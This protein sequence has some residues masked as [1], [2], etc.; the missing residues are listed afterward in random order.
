[1]ASYEVEAKFFVA[2]LAQLRETLLTLGAEQKKERVFEKNIRFETKGNGL[3]ANRQLLRLRQDAEVRLTFKGEPKE[4]ID[5]EVKVREEIEVSVSDFGAM[6]AILER[7]G[8]H[9]EQV[10]EKYR[11]TFTLNGLEVVLDELPYGDF[12]ELEGVEEM[13]KKTAVSLSLPW[14][15]RINTNYLGLMAVLKAHHNLSFDDLT[16]ENFVGIEATVADILTQ[17]T[18][19]QP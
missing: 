2:D 16:F 1:M 3:F 9:P 18:A 7:V 19:E 12:V 13:I 11:E 14:S 17:V 5:T 8:F 6:Q 15:Q 10:Y 4:Q